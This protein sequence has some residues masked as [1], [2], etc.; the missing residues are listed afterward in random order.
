M[1]K[2]FAAALVA[3]SFTLVTVHASAFAASTSTRAFMDNV[4][5]NVDFL[6]QSSRL[7]MTNSKSAKVKTFAHDEATE[8]TLTANAF[9]DWSN[10]VI[11]VADGEPGLQTGRSVAVDGQAASAP[12]GQEE[13]DALYGLNGK[14]FDDLYKQNQHDALA[15]VQADYEAYLATG[16]D[17]ALKLIAARELPNVKKRLATLSKL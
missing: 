16:D 10:Q 13:L 3:G 2:N 11:K 6:D 1:I 12:L 14:D 5:P 8:Q 17:P 9:Y 4:G 15:Q 7:A